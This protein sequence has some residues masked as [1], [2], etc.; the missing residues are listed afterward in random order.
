MRKVQTVKLG[1][2]STKVQYMY[3]KMMTHIL[4]EFGHAHRT[5][6]VKFYGKRVARMLCLIETNELYRNK[7]S[8]LVACM[9]QWLS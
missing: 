1:P 6:Y 3:Y 2:T 5:R 4:C 7:W 8:Q 9:A